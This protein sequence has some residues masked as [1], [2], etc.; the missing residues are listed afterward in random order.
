MPPFASSSSRAADRGGRELSRRRSVYP[1][2]LEYAPAV[3]DARRARSPR[4]GRAPDRAGSGAS[5]SRGRP[6]RR[7]PGAPGG[8]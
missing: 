7:A 2:T 8:L 6:R 1:F 4:A 3:N 5:G